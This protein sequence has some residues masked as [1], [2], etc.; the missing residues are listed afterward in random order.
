M[1]D[2]WLWW[3]ISLHGTMMGSY[4]CMFLAEMKVVALLVSR[5]GTKCCRVNSSGSPKAEGSSSPALSVTAIVPTTSNLV[6]AGVDQSFLF[7]MNTSAHACAHTCTHT[8][9]HAHTRMHAHTHTRTHT[10]ARGVVVRSVVRAWR[11][12]WETVI[13]PPT[14]TYSTSRWRSS[15]ITSPKSDLWGGKFKGQISIGFIV[16]KSN[17]KSSWAIAMV[18]QY[19][20]R[21]VAALSSMFWRYWKLSREKT[22]VK[23]WKMICA[24]KTIVDCSLVP[25]TDATP[26]KFVEKTFVSSHKTSKFVKVFSLKSFPLYGIHVSTGENLFMN[27]WMYRSTNPFFFLILHGFVFYLLDKLHE[28]FDGKI[29]CEAWDFSCIILFT[30]TKFN[31]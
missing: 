16:Q 8:H 28:L 9:T 2:S 4:L 24:E 31:L 11:R 1:T 19:W 7:S 3:R 18:T 21:S 6:P 13:C 29:Q 10:P 12:A 15:K 14:W 20:T 27:E 5:R 17:H 30:C 25:P 26:P 23:W 22:L